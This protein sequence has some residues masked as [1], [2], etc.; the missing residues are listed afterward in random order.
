MF[1]PGGR[2]SRSEQQQQQQQQQPC[3]ESERPPGTERGG[4]LSAEQQR[5]K[6]FN[7]KK[8]DE[9]KTRMQ[10]SIGGAYIID[11]WGKNNRKL[12]PCMRGCVEQQTAG[13]LKGTVTTTT[14]RFKHRQLAS[15]NFYFFTGWPITVN[16]V[17]IGR[18]RCSADT[19]VHP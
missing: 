8:H 11:S 17:K 10:F 14:S 19:D 15:V 3:R 18:F 5:T 9:K 4:G 7:G 6:L 1:S 12:V 13:V 2:W 16:K